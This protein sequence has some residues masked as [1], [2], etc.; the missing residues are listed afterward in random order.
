MSLPFDPTIDEEQLRA[1]AAS[2][3]YDFEALL[4]GAARH[5]QSDAIVRRTEPLTAAELE[6]LCDDVVGG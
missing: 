5:F 4:V 3:G 2:M 6:L 1:T